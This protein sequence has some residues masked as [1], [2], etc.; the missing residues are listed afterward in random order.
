M[1]IRLSDIFIGEFP[2]TQYFGKNPEMYAKYGYK[3]HNGVDWRTPL[4]TQIL[5]AHD[6]EVVKVENDP[7]GY[8]INVRLW[9]KNGGF[10]TIYA[11]L[12]KAVVVVGERVVAGQL[13][14]FADNTGFST[15][16]HLHFSACRTDENGK[17]LNQDN[18]YGGWLNVLD[19]RIFEWDVKNL[20][21]PVKPPS[22]GK[23]IYTEEEMTKMRLERDNNWNLYKTEQAEKDGLKEEVKHL[24]ERV[25]NLERQWGEYINT[26]ANKLDCKSDESAIVGKIETLITVEGGKNDAEGK[27]AQLQGLVDKYVTD[28]DR[29]EEDLDELKKRYVGIGQELKTAET[30]CSEAEQAKKLMSEITLKQK[31]EIE[32]L[33]KVQPINDYTDFNLVLEILERRKE[34]IKK[35]INKILKR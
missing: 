21:E 28:I 5:A 7:N 10:A 4:G 16:D 27:A 31:D 3:G 34:A 30:A 18:G 6:G 9:N 35:I 24:N 33:K 19:K 8:G 2:I 12:Q 29:L 23:G 14:G 17:R 22:N 13:I 11:H 32:K 20:T 25:G 1:K 26:L 15:G